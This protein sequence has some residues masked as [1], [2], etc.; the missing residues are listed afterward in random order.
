MKQTNGF[1]AVFL[2]YRIMGNSQAVVRVLGSPWWQEGGL[3][4]FSGQGFLVHPPSQ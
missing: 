1:K 3:T 2:T 4:G